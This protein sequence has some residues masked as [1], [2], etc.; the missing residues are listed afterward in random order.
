MYNTVQTVRLRNKSRISKKFRSVPSPKKFRMHFYTEIFF[1]K[2]LN[3]LLSNSFIVVEGVWSRS[4]CFSFYNG[5]FHVSDFDS[6]QQEVDF[7]NDNIF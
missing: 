5:N 3:F 7:A 1:V 4:S 2:S 6:N